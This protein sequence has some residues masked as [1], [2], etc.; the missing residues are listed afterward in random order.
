MPDVILFT[1]R[2]EL[3]AA[4]N[5]DEL[6]DVAR[7]QLKT[8][9][10]D[11]NFDSNNWSFIHKNA[12]AQIRFGTWESTRRGLSPRMMVPMA[13]PFLSFSKA[14]IRYS[15][16]HDPVKNPATFRLIALRVLHDALLDV[17]RAVNVTALTPIV[18]NRAVD[19]IRDR[20]VGESLPNYGYAVEGV[21]DFVQKHALVPAPFTWRNPIRAEKGHARV[22]QEF[23]DRRK[24]KLP[25]PTALAAL[26]HVYRTSH[27]PA[28]VMAS[29]VG[30]LLCCAPARISEVLALDLR[31]GYTEKASDGTDQYGLRWR[32]AKGGRPQV[33]WVP[34]PLV[35]LAKDALKR[36]VPLGAD[37]RDLARWY[38]NNPGR[39]YLPEKLEYLRGK[40][41]MTMEEVGLALWHQSG[42][43]HHAAAFCIPNEAG[44][45]RLPVFKRGKNRLVAFSDVERK[46]LL[47][48]PATFPHVDATRGVKCSEALFVTLRHGLLPDYKPYKCILDVVTQSFVSGRFGSRPH[49]S[50][51]LRHGLYED[52]GSEINLRPHQCRH[53]LNMAG[54][55]NHMS[56][57]DIALW[58][59]RKDLRQNR[60]YD[61]V[62]GSD[63]AARMSEVMEDGS[64]V[65]VPFILKTPHFLVLRSDFIQP[66][67]AAGHMT[68]Y[69]H[70]V[71]DFTMLPCT[72]FRDCLNCGEHLCVK[73]DAA[74]EAALRRHLDELR[75]YMATARQ[76]LADE[77]FGADEWVKHYRLTIERAEQ[78][79]AILDNPLVPPGSIIRPRG[80]ESGSRL[81]QAAQRRALAI[82]GDAQTVAVATGT[83]KRLGQVALTPADDQ[84]GQA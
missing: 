65:P 35:D 61:H 56:Q 45:M 82:G 6:V 75:G 3:T 28:E 22:G 52:D 78:L 42:E 38:E 25:S 24:E 72:R 74:K 47:E 8:F 11:L 20:F 5:L 40:S 43:A 57:L 54:Q 67:G 34:S 19:L 39:M 27:A 81:E 46:V 80:V 4:Q 33:K 60:A 30:A 14:Y 84:M 17:T 64:Q 53:Y 23:E 55:R 26:A 10:A 50:M 49:T 77:Q 70:C 73:G 36:I 37:A 68:E 16:A 76:A 9:G 32:P 7:S 69:G 51:F 1:P 71:H 79:V 15:Q 62:S 29:S 59:G 66:S 18:L 31:P 41:D 83:I 13:E 58:S 2:A 21:S 44:G 48:L 12:V 63:L